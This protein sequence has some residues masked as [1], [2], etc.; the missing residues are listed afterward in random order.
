MSRVELW[1]ILVGGLLVTYATRLSFIA[2]F[3]PELMPGWFRSGLRYVPP[4]IL[5]A[6]IAP[7]LLLPGGSLD[8]SLGNERLL[9]GTLAWLVA[10][11]TRSTWLTIAVGMLALWLLN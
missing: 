7:E 2:F 8:F 6:L 10:W 5:A 11:R 9:A 1:V 3:P 4:A